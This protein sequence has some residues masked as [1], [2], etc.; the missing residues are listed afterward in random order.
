VAVF[1]ASDAASYLNGMV[2]DTN[3]WQG[4]DVMAFGAIVIGDEISSA[5]AGQ[6]YV[7]RH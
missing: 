1:L 3:G 2:M 5:S 4:D 6:A 7:V